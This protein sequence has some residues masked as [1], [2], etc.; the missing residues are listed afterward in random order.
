MDPAL[1]FLERLFGGNAPPDSAGIEVP[2][3]VIKRAG[4]PFLL[5]PFHPREAV[6]TLGLYAPQSSRAIVARALLCWCIELA[7]PWPGQRIR[8]GVQPNAPLSRFLSSLA[9][10]AQSPRFG[11]LAGNP[12]SP[13]QRFLL[14]C[15]NAEHRPIAVVKAGSTP[16][17]HELIQHE[18]TFLAA[19]AG[20]F[21]GIPALLKTFH[22]DHVRAFATPFA[23]GRSPREQDESSLPEMLNSWVDLTRQVTLLETPAWRALEHTYAADRQFQIIAAKLRHHRVHP[24]LQ[25]GDFAPWN[26]KV[27]RDGSWTV[28]DWERSE[29]IG[30]PGWDWFHYVLQTGVLVKRMDA[31]TL[32]KRTE[33]LLASGSFQDYASLS[34]VS[35]VERELLLSYLLH[36]VEVIQPSEGR[37][38]SRNLLSA[39]AQCWGLAGREAR[40]A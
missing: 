30:I 12:A 32:V 7:A 3:R 35:G 39:L 38:E 20:R 29:L 26:I 9:G 1:N 2:L 33:A 18:E 22:S 15:F 17:A 28:L 25:H 16:R 5:L 21:K 40:S 34:G 6:A 36:L 11:I 14:L 37:L 31:E 13:G 10:A 4:Q 19:A 27:S 24:C 8:F 23:P